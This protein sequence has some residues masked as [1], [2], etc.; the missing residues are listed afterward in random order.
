MA[1]SCVE[2]E[3]VAIGERDAQLKISGRSA[4]VGF[5]AG[6][7]SGIWLNLD[8]Q[9]VQLTEHAAGMQ[10]DGAASGGEVRAPMH[11]LLLEVFVDVGAAVEVGDRLAILEAMKM[12]HELIAEVAGVVDQLAAQAGSQV[13]ADDLILEITEQSSADT[14]D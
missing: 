13:A 14:T 10:S 9:I 1:D 11:G 6:Q 8:G 7:A 4:L 5:A 12:Q 3:L 2:I